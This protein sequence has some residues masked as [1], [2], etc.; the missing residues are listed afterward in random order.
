LSESS[1]TNLYIGKTLTF[2]LPNGDDW[3]E[4]EL[5]ID[6]H[7]IEAATVDFYNGDFTLEGFVHVEKFGKE[8]SG[9]LRQPLNYSKQRWVV[10]RKD[11]GNS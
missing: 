7:I 10:T 8:S 2:D 9:V 5:G 6:R 11:K 3:S 1:N 4:H